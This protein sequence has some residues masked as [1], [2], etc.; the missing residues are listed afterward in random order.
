MALPNLHF[1]FTGILA[2]LILEDG[3]PSEMGNSSKTRNSSRYKFG[4]KTGFPSQLFHLTFPS[5][6]RKVRRV[7]H[8]LRSMQTGRDSSLGREFSIFNDI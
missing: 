2:E 5:E 3:F 4:L 8:V 7:S 1:R 6:R